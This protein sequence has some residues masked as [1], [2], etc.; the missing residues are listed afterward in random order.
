[1]GMFRLNTFLSAIVKEVLQPFMGKGF[2]HEISVTV[3]VTLVKPFLYVLPDT[4]VK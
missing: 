3:K 1:M 2:N 4:P